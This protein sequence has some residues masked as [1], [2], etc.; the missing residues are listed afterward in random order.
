V[1]PAGQRQRRAIEYL[2]QHLPDSD[3]LKLFDFSLS[4]APLDNV[5]A[6]TSPCLEPFLEQR[7]KRWDSSGVFRC[8]G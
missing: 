6:G 2:R 5:R 8:P 4:G 7:G 3:L 1:A